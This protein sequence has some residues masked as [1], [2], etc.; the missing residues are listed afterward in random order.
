MNQ[1]EQYSF[2]LNIVLPAIERDGLHIKAAGAELVLK[3]TDPSV[4]AFINEARRSVTYSLSRSVVNA[5][6]Y[7]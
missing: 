4:E 3:P 7:L 5:V 6:S 2:I 1:R